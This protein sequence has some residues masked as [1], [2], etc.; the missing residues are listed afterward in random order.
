MENLI[1]CQCLLCVFTINTEWYFDCRFIKHLGK[2][3]IRRLPFFVQSGSKAHVHKQLQHVDDFDS[4]ANFD[5]YIQSLTTLQIYLI[6]ITRMLSRIVKWTTVLK[7][8][9]VKK[10]LWFYKGCY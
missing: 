4:I 2:D 5:I 6:S 9:V 1:F 8:Y 7:F 10:G 3:E